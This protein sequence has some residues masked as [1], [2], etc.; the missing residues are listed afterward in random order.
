MSP[1]FLPSQEFER[2]PPKPARSISSIFSNGFLHRICGTHA[3]LSHALFH[4]NWWF[5]DQESTSRVRQRLSGCYP[6]T[7]GDELVY[8]NRFGF[9][10]DTFST[11]ALAARMSARLVEVFQSAIAD[12]ALNYPLFG[13]LVWMASLCHFENP[14]ESTALEELP[15]KHENK[16]LRKKWK[17][18]EK[19]RLV[20]TCG[21]ISEQSGMHAET[22]AI[23]SEG[24]Y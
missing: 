3:N 20:C 22:T 21:F 12:A 17:L 15:K 8:Q 14:S 10:E 16:S 2:F 5:W 18:L 4:R 1:D 13:A 24:N 19:L 7:L 23:R 9:V 6:Q 11:I